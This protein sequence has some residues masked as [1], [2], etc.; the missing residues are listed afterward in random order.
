MIFITF[1]H[2]V[3]TNYTKPYFNMSTYF[4]TDNEYLANLAYLQYTFVFSQSK[5]VKKQTETRVH[6]LETG[7][8]LGVHPLETGE[9]LVVTIKPDGDLRRRI[10][11]KDGSFKDA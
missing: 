8:K 10:L 9:K 4:P 7:E 6:P 5:E 3:P 11:T 1:V 2:V